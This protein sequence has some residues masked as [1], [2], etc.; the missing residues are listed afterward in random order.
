MLIYKNIPVVGEKTVTDPEGTFLFLKANL[1]NKEI[2][3]I[4][5]YAPNDNHLLFFSAIPEL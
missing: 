4:N 5:V 3:I 2:I 1:H